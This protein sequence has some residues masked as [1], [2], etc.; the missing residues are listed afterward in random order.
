MVALQVSFQLEDKSVRPKSIFKCNLLIHTTYA[1]FEH[2][3]SQAA[4]RQS[5]L[6]RISSQTSPRSLEATLHQEFTLGEAIKTEQISPICKRSL[7]RPHITE[8]PALLQRLGTA[9]KTKKK[10]S[11]KAICR[12]TAYAAVPWP[13]M[14]PNFILG[15][16]ARSSMRLVYSAQQ[17]QTASGARFLSTAS[18]S[19]V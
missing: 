6:S 3:W 15:V 11:C 8:Q 2:S 9:C 10:G 4:C 12:F 5:H 19:T 7:Q 14:N 13:Y 16:A 17:S 18:S 1:I